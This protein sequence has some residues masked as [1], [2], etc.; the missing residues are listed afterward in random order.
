M[1]AEVEAERAECLANRSKLLGALDRMSEKPSDKEVLEN[2]NCKRCRQDWGKIGQE[3]GHCKR[4]DVYNVYFYS[5]HTH[6]RHTR[7]RRLLVQL[8]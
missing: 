7:R 8:Y 3:C 2:G 5:L 1:I 4:E 6:R